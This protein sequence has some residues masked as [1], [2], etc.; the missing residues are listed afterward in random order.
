MPVSDMR[1]L[2][3]VADTIVCGSFGR[4]T[5]PIVVGLAVEVWRPHHVNRP[6]V[7]MPFFSMPMIRVGMNMEQRCGKHPHRCPHQNRRARPR[8]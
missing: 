2:G 8:N 4:I 3:P 1:E 6:T 7:D 5:V